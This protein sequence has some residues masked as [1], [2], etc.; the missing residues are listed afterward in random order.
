MHFKILTKSQ[1]QSLDQKFTSKSC[2]NFS[3]NIVTTQLQ[4]LD[5]LLSI[6]ISNVKT[7]WVGIVKGQSHISQVYL[8]AVSDLVTDKDSQFGSDRNT[9]D[10]LNCRHKRQRD[11]TNTRNKQWLTTTLKRDTKG[12]KWKHSFLLKSPNNLC[13]SNIN[14]NSLYPTYYNGRSKNHKCDLSFH[15]WKAEEIYSGYK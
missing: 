8:T 12:E 11:S 14:L 3:F 5:K 4:N 7:F 9:E 15:L 6:N 2:P 13:S 1:P 10:Y